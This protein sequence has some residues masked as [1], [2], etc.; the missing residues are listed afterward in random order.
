MVEGTRHTS[1]RCLGDLDADFTC[2]LQGCFCAELCIVQQQSLPTAFGY[3]VDEVATLC[4]LHSKDTLLSQA[5]EAARDEIT[6]TLNC[7]MHG[8][9]RAFLMWSEMSVM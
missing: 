4:N 6:P 7:E 2:F 1:K 5:V 3:G 9:A 8:V